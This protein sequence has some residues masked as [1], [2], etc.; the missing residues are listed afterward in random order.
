MAKQASNFRVIALVLWAVWMFS[1]TSPASAASSRQASQ[2]P[3]N[4]PPWQDYGGAIADLDGDGRND[5]ATVRSN[6]RGPK[7]FRYQVELALS[8]RKGVSSFSV[9]AEEGGL[10]IVP[11]DVDGDGDLD[12]VITSARSLTPVGVWINDGHGGFTQGDSTAYPQSIWTERPGIS[13]GDTQRIFPAIASQSCWSWFD[14]CKGFRFW[15]ELPIERLQF[16]DATS[17]FPQVAVSQPRTRA[18]PYSLPLQ[19]S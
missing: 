13:S 5:L 18:P 8:S 7:T 12:L 2:V 1:G 19:T 6:I 3:T 14:V 15:S 10:R 11:R 17:N 4:T 9:S 16:C